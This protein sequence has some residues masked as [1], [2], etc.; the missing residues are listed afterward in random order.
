MGDPMTIKEASEKLGMK[1]DTLYRKVKADP[2]KY[3]AK[4]VGLGS[5]VWTVDG[6]K[7]A[8]IKKSKA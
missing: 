7:I 3:G 5:G 6:R 2:K 4:K 1:H 8:S